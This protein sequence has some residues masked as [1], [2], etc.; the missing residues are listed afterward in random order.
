MGCRRRSLTEYF[1]Y[2]E[3]GIR[4]WEL[5][6]IENNKKQYLLSDMYLG[7]KLKFDSKISKDSYVY[8]SSNLGYSG[9]NMMINKATINCIA[10]HHDMIFPI[11]IILDMNPS[12]L[13]YDNIYERTFLKFINTII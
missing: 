3:F 4:N 2:V 11:R 6:V 7:N 8:N 1:A 9:Y 5:I 12:T 10:T 13:F